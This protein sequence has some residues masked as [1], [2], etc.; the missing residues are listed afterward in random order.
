MHGSTRVAEAMPKFIDIAN[1]LNAARRSDPDVQATWD[2][3]AEGQLRELSALGQ[4]LK[5]EKQLIPR[6]K[7]TEAAD[8]MWCQTSIWAYESLVVDRA[9]PLARWVAWQKRSLR[10]LLFADPAS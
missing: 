7:A 8:I 4:R 5:R 2:A 10:T 1:T 3:P 6:M 9:W